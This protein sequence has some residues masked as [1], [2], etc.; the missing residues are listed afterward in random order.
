MDE[1]NALS[2]ALELNEHA[3]TIS[4]NLDVELDMSYAAASKAIKL[5]T[6][7]CKT[8]VLLIV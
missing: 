5:R 8:P 7:C 2:Q 6:L 1:T 3:R 4:S